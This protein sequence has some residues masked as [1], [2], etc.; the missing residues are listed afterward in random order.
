MQAARNANNTM[1]IEIDNL[2]VQRRGGITCGNDDFSVVRCTKCGSQYL[3]NDEILQLYLDPNDATVSVLYAKGEHI[4][5]CRGCGDGNWTI[6]EIPD[7]ESAMV[8]DGPWAW[9]IAQ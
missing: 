6:D 4:P 9:A 8:M 7:D 2:A 3:Y 1:P 5:P